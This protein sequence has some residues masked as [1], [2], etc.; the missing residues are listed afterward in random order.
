M[1]LDGTPISILRYKTNK[2]DHNIYDF[3][4]R[5][6]NKQ[7]KIKTAQKKDNNKS[8]IIIETPNKSIPIPDSGVEYNLRFF[9]N[10]LNN[11]G[12]EKKPI[13]IVKNVDE[14]SKIIVLPYKSIDM[15]LPVHNGETAVLYDTKLCIYKS[16]NKSKLREYF[17]TNNGL[18]E[19]NGKY[20]FSY[21]VNEDKGYVETFYRYE[22]YTAFDIGDFRFQKIFIT[23]DKIRYKT[24]TTYIDMEYDYYGLLKNYN[25][26][27]QYQKYGFK[28]DIISYST[29]VKNREY[30]NRSQH[31]LYYDTF[32]IN[33]I[34]DGVTMVD[35]S[36]VDSRDTIEYIRVIYDKGYISTSS[37]DGNAINYDEIIDKYFKY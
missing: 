28:E 30:T 12:K 31:L 6:I 21:L 29:S 17:V 9:N 18:F 3:D 23:P 2:K 8:V 25:I 19:D 16:S 27:G 20:C 1:I 37:T 4:Y 11:A 10:V 26:F 5:V 15:Q 36:I 35:E 32:D 13:T 22:D 33:N 34:Y 24:S 7:F 14:E